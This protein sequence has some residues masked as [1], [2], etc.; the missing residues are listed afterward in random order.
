[1]IFSSNKIL[2]MRDERIKN[3]NLIRVKTG[4]EILFISS[5]LQQYTEKKG[6]IIVEYL[7]SNIDTPLDI[8]EANRE[9][10]TVNPRNVYG[11]LLVYLINK[12]EKHSGEEHRIDFLIWFYRLISS[13]D[14]ISHGEEQVFKWMANCWN[15]DVS[16]LFKKDYFI[17]LLFDVPNE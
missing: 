16:F 1:M 2:Y 3:W 15:V 14:K 17:P 6:H 7:T 4:Y 13:E 5:L 8:D 12:F 9:L 10:Q 11:A